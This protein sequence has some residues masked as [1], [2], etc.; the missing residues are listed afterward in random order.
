MKHKIS[1]NQTRLIY[2]NPVSLITSNYHDKKNVFT[3]SWLC[4]VSKNPQLA[5]ISVDKRRA[6]FPLIKESGKYVINIPNL[7]ML[8]D[9]IYCGSVSAKDKDKFQERNFKF[10]VSENSGIIL[11]DAIA[12]VECE[13]VNEF[14][15]GDHVLFVGKIINAGAEEDVF[16]NG[17]WNMD[18]KDAQT[19]SFLG[20]GNYIIT[21]KID[22]KKKIKF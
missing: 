15:V 19:L 7:K 11:D 6:S 9:V 20:E 1:E 8:K 5:M 16:T 22:H 3:V 13:V 17:K 18:N 21:S 2:H 4:A 10:S 14:D 12:F